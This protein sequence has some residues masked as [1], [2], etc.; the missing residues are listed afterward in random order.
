[1]IAIQ[2]AQRVAASTVDEVALV[3]AAFELRARCQRLRHEGRDVILIALLDLRPVEVAPIRIRPQLG[4]VHGLARSTRHLREL[5][6]VVA[7]IGDLVRNDQVVLGIHSNLHVVAHHAST[8]GLRHHRARV[9]IGQRDLRLGLLRE[10]L[11]DLRHPPHLLA[12]RPHLFLEPLSLGDELAGLVAV[13]VVEDIQVTLD[14]LL[15]LLLARLD[16]GRREVAVAAVD[17]LELAAV[18]G[19][20]GLREQLEPAAQLDEPTTHPADTDAVVAPKIGN[21]LEVRCQTAG[22]PH[23]LDI[24]LRFAL[25]P[26]AR[27]HAIEISVDVDLEQQGR[28]IRRPPR[29]RRLCAIEAKTQEIELFDERVDHA[30]RVVFADE[31]VQA[32]WQQRDLASIFSI[33]ES[34]HVAARAVAF[35]QF[36]QSR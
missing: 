28:V 35:P 20:A 33:N 34:L 24:A 16:L 14:A 26:P 32:L 3:E 17:R 8:L 31:V 6:A 13:G 22:Q 18:N 10:L 29:R 11:L 36:R 2:V 19:H 12:Q 15:D 30:D 23:Q 4:L 25:Q 7:H 9:R 1:M 27:L 21:R 5:A